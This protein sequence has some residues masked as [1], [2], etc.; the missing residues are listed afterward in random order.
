MPDEA[1]PDRTAVDP[2]RRAVNLGAWRPFG[3]F[4]ATARQLPA[5]EVGDAPRRRALW[6]M[7]AGVVEVVGHRPFVVAGE[8]RAGEPRTE[9]NCHRTG[10]PG[11]QVAT[12]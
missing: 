6:I 10:D 9:R 12:R 7:K 4:R 1:D 8:Q 2:S 3:P 5:Q 11:Q